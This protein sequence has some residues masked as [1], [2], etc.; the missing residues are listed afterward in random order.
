M[1]EYNRKNDY[2]SNDKISFIIN[3]A[4]HVTNMSSDY[5]CF[6]LETELDDTRQELIMMKNVVASLRLEK[7]NLESEMH[8]M[9]LEHSALLPSPLPS[10][11]KDVSE[12]TDPYGFL[13]DFSLRSLKDDSY[14]DL[15][16]EQAKNLWLQVDI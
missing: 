6:R 5:V 15:A 14:R 10:E 1:T 7:D 13:S 2:Y 8:K 3:A 16:K 9:H 11:R 4:K 12:Q